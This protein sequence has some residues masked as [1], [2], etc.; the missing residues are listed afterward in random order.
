VPLLVPQAD[1][2]LLPP[3]ADQDLPLL[4]L[5]KPSP[6][7]HR[8]EQGQPLLLPVVVEQPPR[9]LEDPQLQQLHVPPQP[10]LLQ[11]LLLLPLLLVHQ[12]HLELPQ[13]LVLHQ[14]P[15][16]LVPLLPLVYQLWPLVPLHHSQDVAI[17]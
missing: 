16:P 9:P 10:L 11:E 13:L 4:P 2:P 17:C 8:G 5:D 12:R 1:S 6:H 15:G 7:L 14:P 3:V